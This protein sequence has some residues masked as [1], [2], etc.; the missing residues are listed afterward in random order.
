MLLHLAEGPAHGWELREA[1]AGWGFRRAAEDPSTLYKLLRQMEAEGS[2]VSEWAPGASGPAR[3]VYRLTGAGQ[4][5][6]HERMADL[7]RQGRRIAALM[8][9]Y[10]ERFP[11]GTSPGKEPAL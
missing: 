11:A 3:R 7:E 1:M 6:L 4:A 9:R 5:R 10:R 8:D 2:L